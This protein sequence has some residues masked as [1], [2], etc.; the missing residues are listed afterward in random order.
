MVHLKNG[1]VIKGVIVEQIPSVSIKIE[2][3]EGNIFVY[4]MDEIE[5]LTK[6]SNRYRPTGGNRNPRQSDFNKPQGYIGLVE[7][8]GGLGLGNWA[9][10]RVSLTMINGYRFLPQFAVGLGVGMEMFMY[11]VPDW[12]Y[13]RET[14]ITLPIFLHLRSDL[15]AGKI[16]PY[17]A[18]NVGYNI[19][20]SGNFFDGLILEP[21]A[22]VAFNIGSKNRLLVGVSFAMNQVKYAI[23]NGSYGYYE[24]KSMGNALKLKVGLSF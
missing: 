23:G 4:K 15:I 14:D 5:K 3:R 19:N 8:G 2:T 18:F 11:E 7:I 13:S 24:E 16:S 6:E 12:G 17:V 20:L 21:M 1:S 9:A 10:D 22:G